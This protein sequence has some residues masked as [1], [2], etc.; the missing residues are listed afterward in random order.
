MDDHTDAAWF[1]GDLSDPW[2]LGIAESLPK[3]FR[4]ISCPGDLPE[5]WGDAEG[6][7][8]P[9]ILVLHRS[10]L[11]ATD[12][13]R[14]ARLT[15]RASSPPRVIVCVGPH[16]RSEDCV[17]WS[18]WA[19]SILPESTAATTLARRFSVAARPML[20][21]HSIHVVVAGGDFEWREM[22]AEVCRAGGYDPRISR[23]AVAASM[24]ADVL[25][26]NAPVLEPDW[27]STLSR[28]ASATRV[29]AV[30]GLA[31][32]D[33]VEE[34]LEAGATACLDAPFDA[35]DLIWLVDRAATGRGAARIDRGH[36]LPKP[37]V[38]SKSAR[39]DR[40]SLPLDATERATRPRGRELPR[41]DGQDVTPA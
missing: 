39:G 12:A 30:I 17:R 15:A 16:V 13:A 32:R 29:I 24:N 37:P 35:D 1:V 14:L 36:A 20:D 18:R 7:N 25:I 5:S 23:D 21:P 28:M 3:G 10:R 4:W 2:V 8:P 19:E 27:R 11:Q 33:L 9:A 31:S 6:E 38:L 34:A 26:W 22:G 41:D 40:E